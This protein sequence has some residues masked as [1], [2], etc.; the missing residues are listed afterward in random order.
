MYQNS[1]RTRIVELPWPDSY[2]EP[3]SGDKRY[4]LLNAALGEEDSEENR[5]RLKLW[6]YRY[7]KV[8]ENNGKPKLDNFMKLWLDLEYFSGRTNSFFGVKKATK[9]IKKDM[10]HL[11]CQEMKEYGELG[12]A[13]LYE[14]LVQAG[15]YYFELCASDKNYTTEIF[16][17]KTIS[18]EKFVNKITDDVFRICY[19]TPKLLNLQ[20]DLEMFTKA[21]TEALDTDYPEQ[22]QGLNAAIKEYR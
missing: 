11:G 19:K 1:R 16:G 15:R 13:L 22:I 6:E 10:D 14:E 21:V 20:D 18:Q 2:Y 3:I 4:E 5:L 17:L 7:G 8:A 9:E 12:L